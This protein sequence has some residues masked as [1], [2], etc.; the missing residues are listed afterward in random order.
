MIICE[1]AFSDP[2]PKNPKYSMREVDFYGYVPLDSQL[3][4]SVESHRL[5]LR[6]NLE[7]GKFEI[8]RFFHGREDEE[9]AFSGSFQ[10][11]LDFAHTE[12]MKYWG[13]LGEREKDMACRHKEP[14]IDRM[15]CPY[16]GKREGFKTL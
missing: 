4:F 7:T 16:A 14:V 12:W 8:Y 9:V 1:L 10:E 15:F 13:F 6:K 2:D 11:A 3:K 5:S